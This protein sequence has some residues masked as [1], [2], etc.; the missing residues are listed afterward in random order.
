MPL[1]PKNLKPLNELYAMLSQEANNFK[2]SLYLC[3]RSTSM[4]RCVSSPA[5]AYSC[6]IAMAHQL[7][8][9]QNELAQLRHELDVARKELEVEKQKTVQLKQQSPPG[10]GHPAVVEG[11]PDTSDSSDPVIFGNLSEICDD[12]NDKDDASKMVSF[13]MTCPVSESTQF[14]A[15]VDSCDDD[16]DFQT[17]VKDGRSPLREIINTPR[18][19]EFSSSSRSATNHTSAGKVKARSSPVIVIDHDE[20]RPAPVKY[21]TVIRKKNERRQLHASDCACCSEVFHKLKR[22]HGTG[23]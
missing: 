23:I 13:M 18:L 19:P 10:R 8:Q 16:D 14:P 9:A 5:I 21:Q 3:C 17:P 7:E 11:T 20:T 2:V 4:D 1:K 15:V 22:N 6:C 12:E